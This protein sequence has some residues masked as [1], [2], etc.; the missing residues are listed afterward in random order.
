MQ[1]IMYGK[2]AFASFL[3]PSYSDLCH[4]R[5]DLIT[6]QPHEIDIHCLVRDLT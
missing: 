1:Y 2:A 3:I 6:Q 4:V 5:H